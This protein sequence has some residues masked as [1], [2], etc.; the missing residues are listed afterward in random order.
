MG[1]QA[2]PPAT[3]THAGPAR[4]LAVNGGSS[5]IKAALY[6]DEHELRMELSAVVDAIGMPAARMV[7]E[8][9]SGKMLA[10][11]TRDL[12]DHR[13]AFHALLEW[14]S[15]HQPEATIHAVGHR[16]VHGG[17]RHVR[18]EIITPQV[19]SSLRELVPLART[20]LPDEIAL[21]EATNEALP[22]ALQIAC[23]DTAFHRSMPR[24]AQ[25]YALPRELSVLGIARYGFHGLSYEY[26]LHELERQAGAEAAAGRVI[27][28][29]LG[30]GASM[31]AIQNRLSRD[32]TMGFTPM[33]GLVMSTRT[34]DLDP[35]VLIFLLRERGLS[36]EELEAAVR[37]QGGLL[38]VSGFSSDMRDLLAREHDDD[39]AAGAV[40]L[41]CYQ[42]KKSLA[43]LAAVLGGVE[44]VVFTGGIGEH[45]AEVRRR[46]CD[47]L[48]FLGIEI[49]PGRNERDEPVISPAGS[50]VMVRVIATN[51]EYMIA[52]HSRDL[53]RTT[54]SL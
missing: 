19:M 35:G 31:V 5:S 30:N 9:A 17:S 20:H 44:T 6:V 52:L 16:V 14:L 41:F 18:P 51:E 10:S 38:G 45:A 15:G 36:P 1:K 2:S 39:L 42:A 50:R 47:N 4:I 54:H 48:G 27:I 21:I 37:K 28:A 32:T 24:V 34:G 33:G 23:F 26:I 22:Q 29:H 13:T 53:L 49:D 7:I 46:I 12:R 8:D 3:H 40:A 43:S 11:E 25:Q